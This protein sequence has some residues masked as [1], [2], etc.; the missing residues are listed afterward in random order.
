MVLTIKEAA[1]RLGLHPSHVY[2]MV[3]TGELPAY[4]WASAGSKQ[5]LW[6]IDEKEL[7]EWMA[8]RRNQPVEPTTPQAASRGARKRH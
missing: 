6:R 2:R 7:S 5:H 4:D 8:A 3:R 1:E